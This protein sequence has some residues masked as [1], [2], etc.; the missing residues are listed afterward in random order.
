MNAKLK[1]KGE[2]EKVH[3]PGVLQPYDVALCGQDLIGD[4]EWEIAIVTN[5]KINCEICIR[6][7]VECKKIKLNQ[8]N[9]K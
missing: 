5:E 3:H 2:V 9:I 7:I 1:I 4:T 6:I 8:L